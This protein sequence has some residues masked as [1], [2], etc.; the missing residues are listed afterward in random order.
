M[1]S[2]GLQDQFTPSGLEAYIGASGSRFKS[3]L[4]AGTHFTDPVRMES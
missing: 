2:G 3:V 1:L 4:Y